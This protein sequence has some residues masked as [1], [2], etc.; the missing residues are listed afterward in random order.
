MGDQLITVA[1]TPDGYIFIIT[2]AD[3][4]NADSIVDGNFVEPCQNI[5]PFGEMLNWLLSRKKGD[6]KGPVRY[7]QS[8]NG[9]LQGDFERLRNDICEL[10]W[11]TECI[12]ISALQLVL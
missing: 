4:R 5:M 8:Q 7:I 10:G 9:N 2:R 6:R 1:E 11:A 3:S 12:G